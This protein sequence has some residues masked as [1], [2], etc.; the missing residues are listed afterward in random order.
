MPLHNEKK[1]IPP[2]A[3]ILCWNGIRLGARD[4]DFS[5]ILCIRHSGNAGGP[6][7]QLLPRTFGI[8]PPKIGVQLAWDCLRVVWGGWQW[9]HD[10]DYQTYQLDWNLNILGGL[11]GLM[12][13][14]Y[15]ISIHWLSFFGGFSVSMQQNK[16][17]TAWKTLVI[18]RKNQDSSN[19]SEQIWSM[20]YIKLTKT[21]T[22]IT[23]STLP[24]PTLNFP[25]FPHLP[26]CKAVVVAARNPDQLERSGTGSCNNNSKASTCV[27]NQGAKKGGHK[28][29]NLKCFMY[30]YLYICISVYLYNIYIIFI[31]YVYHIYVYI[32]FVVICCFVS[33]EKLQ[34]RISWPIYWIKDVS[35]S[36]LNAV[37]CEVW[38][39][40]SPL[41][42]TLLGWSTLRSR[43]DREGFSSSSK[44]GVTNRQPSN[45]AFQKLLPA[46]ARAKNLGFVLYQS[47]ECS[48]HQ[49]NGAAR[50]FC[51][52]W[53]DKTWNFHKIYVQK[54]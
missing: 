10:D 24:A 44:Q 42:M 31:S 39:V 3:P 26:R 22:K 2:W 53:T 50:W 46:T 43:K 12:M 11:Q 19:N 52:K 45:N 29:R 14:F 15:Y 30:I 20:W 16:G 7:L 47:M 27:A 41:Q 48:K 17:S 36:F 33:N 40:P 37:F 51:K 38:V 34:H 23:K 4:H 35:K 5:R 8:A 13:K 1:S 54:N 9:G 18:L 6:T 25:H 28:R 21:H 32:I 49:T